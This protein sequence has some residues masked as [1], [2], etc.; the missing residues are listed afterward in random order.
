MLWN[1]LSTLLLCCSQFMFLTIQSTYAGHR[2]LQNE[3]I[4]MA[5][6]RQNTCNIFVH[7]I[8]LNG[9][10]W[11]QSKWEIP[12]IVNLLFWSM[13]QY[14]MSEL[15]QFQ[16]FWKF[17][18]TLGCYNKGCWCWRMQRWRNTELNWLCLTWQQEPTLYLTHIAVGL[19]DVV[20][21]NINL[22]SV[23]YR[24]TGFKLWLQK[25]LIT[26]HSLNLKVYILL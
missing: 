15:A 14:Y 17:S 19:I 9:L 26:V 8:N 7:F 13:G 11:W 25:I 5:G 20:E 4:Q 16:S 24:A 21:Q 18:V 12:L 6:I 1:S 10:D 3:S 2:C 23:H 22:W